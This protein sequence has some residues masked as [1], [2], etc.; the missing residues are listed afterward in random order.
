M[1]DNEGVIAPNECDPPLV[2]PLCPGRV[3]EG[4]GGGQGQQTTVG[5]VHKNIDHVLL[6]DDKDNM[7]ICDM[8]E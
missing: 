6:H 7:M 8:Q 3:Q 5:A 4:G 2:S 1:G